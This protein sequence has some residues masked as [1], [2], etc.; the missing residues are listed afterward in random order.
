MKYLNF[1]TF[2]VSPIWPKV[3]S[4]YFVISK[5]TATKESSWSVQVQEEQNQ[6]VLL[7]PLIRVGPCGLYVKDQWAATGGSFYEVIRD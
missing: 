4:M 6:R 7:Y 2:V 1:T 3:A 5:Y